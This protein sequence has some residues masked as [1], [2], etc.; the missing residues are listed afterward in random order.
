MGMATSLQALEV[1]VLQPKA[2]VCLRVNIYIYKYIY[3]YDVYYY[4]YKDRICIYWG[5]WRCRNSDGSTQWVLAA[6]N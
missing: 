4:L 5:T 1:P 6:P 2:S 3:K